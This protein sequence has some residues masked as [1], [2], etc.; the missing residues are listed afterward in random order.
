[1]TLEIDPN[2]A[3][4]L[5]GTL[6]GVRVLECDARAVVNHLP[7]QFQGRVTSVICGIPLVL[8]PLA[9]QKCFVAAR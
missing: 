4:H 1:M 5:R 9:D 6:R 3:D 7:E 8:L 2:L